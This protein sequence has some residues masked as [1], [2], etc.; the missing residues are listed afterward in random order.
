MNTFCDVCRKALVGPRSTGAD[1]SAIQ[2]TQICVM[3]S[4]DKDH[5]EYKP[6]VECYGKNTFNVCTMCC[7]KALGCKPVTEEPKP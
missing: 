4:V 6:V 1:E 2:V 3:I 5:F 7:L